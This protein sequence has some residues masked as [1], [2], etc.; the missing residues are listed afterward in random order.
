MTAML[1]LEDGRALHRSNLGYCGML[2][3]IADEVSD[4]HS[5]FRI[6]LADMSNRTS[7]FCEFDLR[8]L[9]D[10]DRQEFWAAANRAL[11]KLVA[12]RGPESIWPNSMYAGESLSHLMK[13][14]R[15]I[16]AGDP[17][18]RLNDL[19]ETMDFSGILEDLDE[20]WSVG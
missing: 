16:L 3:L 20:L 8:G 11:S 4:S 6:W 1:F 19:D 12:R 10:G 13:M 2:Q 17:P 7:P 14:H 18:S 9:T 5:R 15:S